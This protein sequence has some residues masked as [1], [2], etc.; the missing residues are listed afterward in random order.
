MAALLPDV[1]DRDDVGVV[2]STCDLRLGDEALDRLGILRQCLGQELD[3]HPTVEDGVFTLVDHAHAA[4]SDDGIDLILPKLLTDPRIH[5][6]GP[7]G[8]VLI[9]DQGSDCRQAHRR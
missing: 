3:R 5:L 8:F 4:F 7:R 6:F 9:W 1:V 2:Q